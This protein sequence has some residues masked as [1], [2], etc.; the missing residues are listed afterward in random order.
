MAKNPGRTIIFD[1]LGNPVIDIERSDTERIYK[2]GDRLKI[3]SLCAV[4]YPE[5]AGKHCDCK[6][7]KNPGNPYKR[8]CGAVGIV[9]DTDEAGHNYLG[10]PK[11]GLRGLDGDWLGDFLQTEVEKDET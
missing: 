3:K 1:A 8:W 9:E 5:S 2:K 10:V 4:H 11:Y 6:N 7:S